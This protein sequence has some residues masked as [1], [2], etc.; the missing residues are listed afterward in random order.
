[1][2]SGFNEEPPFRVESIYEKKKDMTTQPQTEY[3]KAISEIA[4]AMPFAR[5]V[6]LYEFAMFLKAHPLPAEETFEQIMADEALWDAQFAA[7]SD[8]QFAGLVASVREEIT[9]GKTQPMFDE[10]GEFIERE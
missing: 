10:R 6:Q 4:A 8:D 2:L 7:T 1:M 5:T 3:V 9:A